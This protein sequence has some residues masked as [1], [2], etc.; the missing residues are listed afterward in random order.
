M[1]MDDIALLQEYA[2]TASETAFAALVAR[3]VGLVYSAAL[4]QVRDPHQ[5]EDVTQVVFIVLA[6][7]ADKLS[8]HPGLSGWLLL[9]TRYAANAHIRASVRRARQEQEAA[10]QS[11]LTDSSP[12]DWSRLEPFL[13]E[14]MASLGVTDRAV[15]ALRYFENKTAAEIGLALKLSE[16]A[17]KKRANRA[18]EKL[19][20]ILT[21]R[22]VTLSAVAIVG[23]LSAK[24]V[25]AAPAGL[26]KAVTA[27]A[28][29]K[30]TAVGIAIGCMVHGTLKTL[31]WAKYKTVVVYGATA[32]IAGTAVIIVL[33][34]KP[35]SP[36]VQIINRTNAVAVVSEPLADITKLTL[37][38]PPGGLA[39]QPDGKILVG[40]TLFG[41]LL[42]AKS[43][44]LGHWSRG[45]LRLNPDGSLDRNFICDI[46]RSD[47]SSQKAK[48]ELASN[49][50]ILLSGVFKVV[51]KIPRP[52]YAMLQPNG[53][54]DVSFEPWRGNT[55]I[56]GFTGLPAGVAK[57]AWLPDGSIGI[58][59]ESVEQTNVN[60]P[61]YP[62]TAYRLDAT[63]RWIKPATNVLA[64]TFSRP[65]G[66]ITTLGSVG[67]WARRTIDWTND[68]PASPRPPIRYGSQILTVAVSPPVSDMPFENWTNM[69]SANCAAKVFQALFQ[70][71]PIEL[72][73]FA[74]KL[75]DG[76]AIIAIRDKVINGG[77]TAPGR[78]MRFDKNWMPD[79]SF[80]NSYEADLRSELRIKRQKDGKYLVGGLF[81]KMN[82]EDFPGLVRLNE[83]GQ[84]DR[85]FHCI[86]TNSWQGRIMDVA[87][88]D[89]GRIVICGFFSTVNGVEV[90]HIA[91]LNPDGSL[92]QTFKTPFATME[93]FNRDRF[94]KARR[95]PVT[96]LTKKKR[97]NLLPPP[98]RR[99]KSTMLMTW[100]P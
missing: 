3:H 22:G 56:P 29:A 21:K 58:M 77:M 79:F 75:P 1:P 92:D 48:V 18:L 8:R 80:T 89:D 85:S 63:G 97:R 16:E 90:P 30:G 44:A 42:D 60:F 98:S 70:E 72:C 15:L 20:K 13:D 47:S 99:L 55:N 67:F 71:V 17:A 33:S 45:A 78:F 76:G 87:I 68:A 57:T 43:G 27:V 88:Q 64:A 35:A 2:R 86:T 38:T 49:G 40:T 50:N 66:L 81:G 74:V 91:R 24:S 11:K 14:A 12:A 95:V 73:R 53:K 31:A 23:A 6:R 52:G 9:T 19:R 41:V 5:A 4:R 96:Q 54:L 93:Q 10:M 59:S 36:P 83:D 84:I 28:V 37:S 32:L 7:K 51:D 25:Q 94:G 62:P 100:Y 65:S 26:A 82:G 46:G 34:P 69:P 61:H 39:V